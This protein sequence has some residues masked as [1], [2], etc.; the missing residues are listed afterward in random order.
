VTLELFDIFLRIVQVIL[1]PLLGLLL[2]FYWDQ[3][4]KVDDLK[5]DHDKLKERL[6]KAES[7]LE[8]VPTE[9][10]LHKLAINLTA[11]GGDLK[12]VV[13]KIEGMNK[14]VERMERVVTRHE[15]FLLNNGGK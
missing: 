10:T 2:K 8:K 15:D 3:R 12:A 11:L 4:K 7:C 13:E 6:T 1:I 14:S 9:E 5:D